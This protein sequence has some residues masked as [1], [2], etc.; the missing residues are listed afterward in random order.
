MKIAMPKEGE[1][2]NQHF[3]K[4]KNFAVIELEENRIV[5]IK[6]VSTETLQHNHE[7]LAEFLNNEGVEVVITGG[8]GEGAYK[9][10]IE[11]GFKV[12]RGAKGS[13][14]SVVEEYLKGEL[15]DKKVLCSH[16]HAHASN[17]G[18][19]KL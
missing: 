5:N 1:L 19:K 2:L 17:E 6:E 11:K 8:I 9:P 18:L 12:I 10:L 3:G 13:V 14:E 16:H 7:G 4:S 15:K